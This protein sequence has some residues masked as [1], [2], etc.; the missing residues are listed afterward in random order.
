[1]S[2][3]SC[4]SDTRQELADLIRVGR[5]FG[6]SLRCLVGMSW[7]D[8]GRECFGHRNIPVLGSRRP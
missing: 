5:V 7:E 3:P 8:R 4:G 1:M 6:L 2:W